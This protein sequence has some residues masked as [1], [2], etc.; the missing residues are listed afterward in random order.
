MVAERMKTLIDEKGIKYTAIARKTGLSV[1]RV[2]KVL[3]RQRRMLADEMISIC[4][5]TDIRLADLADKE[6]NES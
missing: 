6:V 4:A 5:A 2:S 3:N 1:D